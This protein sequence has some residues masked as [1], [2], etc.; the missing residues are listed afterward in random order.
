MADRADRLEQEVAAL[1]KQQESYD[2][3]FWLEVKV[4]RVRTRM[5]Q[6][7][8][9]N[10]LKTYKTYIRKFEAAERRI[11]VI[12]LCELCRLYGMKVAAFLQSVGIQ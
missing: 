12:E 11:D 2:M 9:T 7:D 4:A 8:V 1:D 6:L 3:Q 10:K 5:S